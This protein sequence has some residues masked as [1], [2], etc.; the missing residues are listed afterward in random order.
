MF[1]TLVLFTIIVFAVVGAV[2]LADHT[3]RVLLEWGGY[4]VDTSFAVPHSA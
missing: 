3:G 4:R 1:R 2:Y